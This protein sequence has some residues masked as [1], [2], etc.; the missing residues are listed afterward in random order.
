MP[1]LYPGAEKPWPQLQAAAAPRNC[2]KVETLDDPTLPISEICKRC[3]QKQLM[4]LY[5]IPKY[6]SVDEFLIQVATMRGKLK[7]GGTVDVVAAAKIVLQDWNDGKIPYFTTPPKRNSEIKG[8]AA[9]MPG[10]SGEFDLAVVMENEKVQVIDALDAENEGAFEMDTAGEVHVELEEQE[11]ELDTRGMDRDD[12]H[13]QEEEASDDSDG[14]MDVDVEPRQAAK[15]S[16]KTQ[17]AILYSNAGQLNPKKVK[18]A[19][20]QRKKAAKNA[21]AD[22]DMEGGVENDSDSDFD[23]AAMPVGVASKYEVL[24]EADE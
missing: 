20:R 24:A 17:A 16:G 7:R 3:P 6:D 19:R 5:R 21:D 12:D 22:I 4:G 15:A 11:E 9:V 14:D 8:S 13:S 1:G 18:Q 10:W 2:I 23:F